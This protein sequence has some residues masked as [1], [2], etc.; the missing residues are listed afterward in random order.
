MVVSQFLGFACILKPTHTVHHLH[1]LLSTSQLVIN[2]SVKLT[3]RLM[4]ILYLCWFTKTLI[5]NKRVYVAINLRIQLSICCSRSQHPPILQLVKVIMLASVHMKPWQDNCI[6]PNN[7]LHLLGDG[8]L[9][10]LKIH[11]L[12]I[13][14][15]MHCLTIYLKVRC[16]FQPL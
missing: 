15:F 5:V 8:T 4:V 3:G 12:I 2:W 1:L 7:I 9:I 10:N 13:C 14:V 11:F 16:C 6:I